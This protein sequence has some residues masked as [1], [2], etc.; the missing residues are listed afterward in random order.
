MEEQTQRLKNDQVESLAADL[1]NIQATTSQA[2]KALKEVT[3]YYQSNTKRMKYKTFLQNGYLIG[4]GAIESAHRNVIQQR[5][6]LSGQRWS[7]DGAQRIANIRA[8]KKSKTWKILIDC[9]NN[10]A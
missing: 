9:I 6:K 8:C 4:S 1:K 7:K 2:D 5:M 10:A 3:A